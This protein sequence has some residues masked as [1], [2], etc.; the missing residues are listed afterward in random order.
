[1]MYC[2]LSNETLE[3]CWKNQEKFYIKQ[4]FLD[5]DN[6]ELGFFISQETKY[7]KSR[8][9]KSTYLSHVGYVTFVAYLEKDQN[10]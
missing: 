9:K 8:R 10:S 6:S 4:G 7:A 1:M 3:F 2:S 5:F